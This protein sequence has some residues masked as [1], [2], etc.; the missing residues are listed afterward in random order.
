MMR[1][2]V[3]NGQSY[4]VGLDWFPLKEDMKRAE[5]VLEAEGYDEKCDLS[6]VLE[7]QYALAR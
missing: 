3:I 2:V 5:L 1:R 6:V 7:K 4:A